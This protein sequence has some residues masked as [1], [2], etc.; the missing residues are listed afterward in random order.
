[1]T[2][3]AVVCE[4]GCCGLSGC[5]MIILYIKCSVCATNHYQL[6]QVLSPPP[7]SHQ[8]LASRL[9]G[10]KGGEIFVRVAVAMSVS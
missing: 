3:R 4:I 2:V 10:E 9:E 7:P 8:I 1:M 5:Y 6:G